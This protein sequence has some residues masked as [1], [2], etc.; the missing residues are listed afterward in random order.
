MHETNSNTEKLQSIDTPKYIKVL[1]L[2]YIVATICTGI[3]TLFANILHQGHITM[4]QVQYT[5]T[6]LSNVLIGFIFLGIGQVFAKFLR[7]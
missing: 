7:K 3:F 2:I 5:I 4:G 1:S 6:A